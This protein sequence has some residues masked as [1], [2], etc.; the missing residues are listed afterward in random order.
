MNLG[1]INNT[2]RA[3]VTAQKKKESN[4]TNGNPSECL[5]EADTVGKH[6]PDQT[7]AVDRSDTATRDDL[8]CDAATEIM[9]AE[10]KSSDTYGEEVFS[11][12]KTNTKPDYGALWENIVTE[13]LNK[14]EST[15]KCLNPPKKA[16]RGEFVKCAKCYKSFNLKKDL[17]THLALVHKKE[18]NC[19]QCEKSFKLK[20]DLRIHLKLVHKKEDLP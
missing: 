11:S 6:K 4:S 19:T 17:R 16:K 15:D 3:F 14:E 7:E 20:K 10:T 8:I 5:D 1:A 12:E 13:A 18:N 2:M 9:G